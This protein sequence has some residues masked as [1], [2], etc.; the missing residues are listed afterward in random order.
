MLF[1]LFL[2]CATSC[3]FSQM[4]NAI[5]VY[6][7]PV[8]GGNPEQQKYFFD[9]FKMEL[10]SAGYGVVDT[11]AESNYM[12]QF[13]IQSNDAFGSD[14]DEKQYEVKLA[15]LNSSDNSEVV[16]FTFPFTGL[17]EMNDWN[18]Y[19][20]YRAMANIPLDVLE[21][22]SRLMDEQAPAAAIPDLW[23]NKWM[24]VS[25]ALG[26]DM[27][28]FVNQNTLSAAQGMV[29]PGVA[30]GYE[31]QF[32]NFLSVQAAGKFRALHDGES[33]KPVLA[34]DAALK[35]VVKPGNYMMLE[36]YFGAEYTMSLSPG[37]Q[38]PWLSVLAGTQVGFRGIKRDAFFID[39][40]MAYSLLGE[41]TLVTENTHG[42]LIFGLLFGWKLGF[43]DRKR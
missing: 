25:F 24:Y 16:E 32:L 26:G 14:P 23:R 35:G 43:L 31:L 28:F 18:Q 4:R 34:F 12:M 6:I 9:N 21:E 7:P 37:T 13:T 41:F 27:I 30:L 33:Y 2:L 39:L 38:I 36:P 11:Q 10:S 5:R 40:S 22:N 15:L 17:D 1:L 8:S 42:T 19:L 3:C 29:M 20:M